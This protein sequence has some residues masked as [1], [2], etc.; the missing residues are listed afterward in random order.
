MTKSRPAK[1]PIIFGKN[2]NGGVGKT[3]VIATL[4]H[5]MQTRGHPLYYVEADDDHQ[6]LLKALR[7]EIPGTLISLQKEFGYTLLGEL[8]QNPNIIGPILIS[9]PGGAIEPFIENVSVVQA[10]AAEAGRET[11]VV[12]PMD[13]TKDSY[14]HLQDVIDMVGQDHVWVLRNLVWGAAQEFRAFN[15]SKIGTGLI[16]AGRVLDFPVISDAI[17]SAFRNDRMSHARMA[18][19]GGVAMPK[20]LAAMRLNVERALERMLAEFGL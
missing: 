5:L 7:D 9:A 6:D 19:E 14:L 20:R 13:K 17:V 12:W 11:F 1:G 4:I 16:E 10:I 8:A 2:G 15:G 3:E 18:T